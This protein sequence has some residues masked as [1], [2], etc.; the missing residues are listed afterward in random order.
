MQLLLAANFLVF[1]VDKYAVVEA[2]SNGLD[3]P[4]T[5]ICGAESTRLMVA[6][7]K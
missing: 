6:R 4:A 2:F 1:G 3:M 5:Q 7:D